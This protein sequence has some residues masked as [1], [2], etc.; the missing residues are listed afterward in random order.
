MDLKF[1][2]G[3]NI[4]MKIPAH[5]YENTAICYTENIKS[6]LQQQVHELGTQLDVHCVPGWY[7]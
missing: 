2:P 4:A 6:Q 3:R 5:E 1:E 7:F